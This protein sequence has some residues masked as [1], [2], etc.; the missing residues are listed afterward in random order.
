MYKPIPELSL[1]ENDNDPLLFE[2][3]DFRLIEELPSTTE[4]VSP[5]VLSV[6]IPTRPLLLIIKGLKSG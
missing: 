4:S 1:P 6:R 2:E 5:S 3:V